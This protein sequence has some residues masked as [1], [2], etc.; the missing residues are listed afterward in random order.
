MHSFVKVIVSNEFC[1]KLLGATT[2]SMSP[3][4]P[5]CFTEDPKMIYNAGEN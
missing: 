4:T 1:R 3:L 2:F 5:G